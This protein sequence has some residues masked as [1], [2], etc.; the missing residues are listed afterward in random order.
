MTGT[1]TITSR[2]QDLAGNW[3]QSVMGFL[4]AVRSHPSKA[5]ASYYSRYFLQYYASM[6]DSL[7]ELRRVTRR[8]GKCV[9][10]LQDS[11]YKDIHLDLANHLSEMAAVSGWTVDSQSDFDV[12]CTKAALNPRARKYRSSFTAKETVLTL[13]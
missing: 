9:L 3:G 10:V 1:P 5:S 8:N 11:Y 13:A 6:K 4:E 12:P 7:L 2:E